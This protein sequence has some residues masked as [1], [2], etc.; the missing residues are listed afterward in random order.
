MKARSRA[1]YTCGPFDGRCVVGAQSCVECSI[2]PPNVVHRGSS[3]VPCLEY[4]WNLSGSVVIMLPLVGPVASFDQETHTHLLVVSFSHDSRWLTYGS[5]FLCTTK[6]HNT[7]SNEA[8]L[9][10]G[11]HSRCNALECTEP[12]V[13]GANEK[14]SGRLGTHVLPQRGELSPWNP[15]L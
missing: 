4:S 13:Q 7:R 9:E 3:P 12:E 10:P 5:M 2:L 6:K 11:Y 15:V 1:D 14:S 8:N